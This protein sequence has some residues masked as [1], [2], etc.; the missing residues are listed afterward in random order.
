[1]GHLTALAETPEL[2]EELARSARERL[3]T[4]QRD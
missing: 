1:M 4:K 3:W 2:A